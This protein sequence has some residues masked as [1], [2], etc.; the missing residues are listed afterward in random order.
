MSNI[1]LSAQDRVSARSALRRRKLVAF[2]FVAPLLAF[3]V[4]AFVAPIASMLFRS[5]HEP[6]VSELIPDTLQKMQTWDGQK[7]PPPE[8]MNQFKS[9]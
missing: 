8:V 2:L 4:F 7:M 9:F 5:I 6:T 3:L 1:A